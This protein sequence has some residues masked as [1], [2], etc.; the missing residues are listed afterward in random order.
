M[1]RLGILALALIAAIVFCA[2]GGNA[3]DAS[4]D[5]T[6]DTALED[7]SADTAIYPKIGFSLA[8]TEGFYEQ[9]V[10]DI[11][12]ACASLDYDIQIECADSAAQQ[13]DDI[14]SLLSAGVVVIVLDPVDVD[15]LETV[16]SECETQDVAVINI[17][18]QVN[19]LVSSL[20]SP[21]YSDI[22]EAAGEYAVDLF[23]EEG[24]GC[25]ML[26]TDYD[27]FIMQW[28]SDGF[29]AAINEDSDDIPVLE[30]YCG[31]DQDQAY[32]DTAEALESA[33]I[34]FIFAQNAALGRSAVQAVNEA[35]SDAVIVVCG[36]DMDIIASVEAGD[37][38]AAIFFSPS[39]IAE[40][41]VYYADK[42]TQGTTYEPPEYVEVDYETVTADNAADYYI[43]DAAYAEAQDE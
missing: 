41:A 28:M 21:N 3:V 4:A 42:L 26:K 17:I 14:E 6:S 36:G 11:E 31:S 30:Y 32:E 22:G 10:L 16:L 43:E 13:Q 25:M 40:E 20:I 29:K 38:Y 12:E 24:G 8:G 35:G 5:L 27:S 33:E 37:I 18:D 19:G 34:D 7:D 23:G 39:E 15:A 9:L 1:K 2:C